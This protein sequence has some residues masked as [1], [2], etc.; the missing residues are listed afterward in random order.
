M[1]KYR[2][3]LDDEQMAVL[4]RALDLYSRIGLGQLSRHCKAWHEHPEGGLTVN[5]DE[6]MNCSGQPM[7][8]CEVVE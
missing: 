4:I 1:A 7:P 3:E 6:P 5:F 8:K 2:I